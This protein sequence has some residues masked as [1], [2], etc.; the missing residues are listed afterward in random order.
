MMRAAAPWWH[1]KPSSRTLAAPDW[2]AAGTRPSA[3][4]SQAQAVGATTTPRR[5]CPRWRPLPWSPLPL[6]QLRTTHPTGSRLN[7]EV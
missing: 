2:C 6:P 1:P 7:S 4:R 3:Q 5:S